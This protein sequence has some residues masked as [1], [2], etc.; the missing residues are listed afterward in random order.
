[1][2][3]LYM[4]H[5]QACFIDIFLKKV[6]IFAIGCFVWIVTTSFPPF[7]QPCRWQGGVGTGDPP[8]LQIWCSLLFHHPPYPTLDIL[9][10]V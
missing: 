8:T 5:H 2:V 4:T 3:N 10:V 7:Q 1:M 9:M 6:V